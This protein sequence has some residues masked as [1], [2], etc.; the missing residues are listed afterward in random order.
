MVVETQLHDANDEDDD[1]S[2]MRATKGGGG[3][4]QQRVCG[5]ESESRMGR[6]RMGELYGKREG[7]D[8]KNCSRLT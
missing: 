2:R 3:E 6:D 7:T 8:L 1:D 5:R 4:I